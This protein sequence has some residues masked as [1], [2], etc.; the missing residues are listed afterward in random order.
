[1]ARALKIPASNLPSATIPRIFAAATR[2]TFGVRSPVRLQNLWRAGKLD[3]LAI[4]DTGAR[5]EHQDYCCSAD[6]Q[7]G[8]A[9]RLYHIADATQCG[10]PR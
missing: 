6:A 1:M 8:A 10:L 2:L 7:K 4:R 3:V 9:Q 5:R